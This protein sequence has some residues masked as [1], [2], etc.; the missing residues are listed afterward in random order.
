MTRLA[1]VIPAHN[2]ADVLADTLDAIASQTRS[3]DGMQTHILVVDDGSSDGTWETLN[4]LRV[5]YP[6]LEGIRLTRQFGKEAALDCGLHAVDADLV[7]TMDADGQHPPVLIPQMIQRWQ[8]RGAAVVSAVKKQRQQDGHRRGL[9]ARIYYR[10]FRYSSGLDI[11]H[12]SDYKLLTRQALDAYKSLPERARFY[13]GLVSWTGFA[14]EKLLFDPPPRPGGGSRW[15]LKELFSY[16]LE[17]LASFTN[18]PLQLVLWIGFL[19]LGFSLLLGLHSLYNW[20]SGQAAEGFTT[21][22]MVILLIGSLIMLS[23]GVIGLYVARLYEEIKRRPL[24]IEAERLP[25][26]DSGTAG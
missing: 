22:I 20:F 3:L 16:G 26:E 10:L 15:Q 18:A 6:N 1:I 17:S 4:Q 24:Y 8:D 5:Q 23:L 25:P 7:I 21:V 11:A 12:S 9:F 2:E 14:E 13:R 19:T